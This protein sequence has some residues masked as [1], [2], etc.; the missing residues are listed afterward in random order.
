MK[1]LVADDSQ[2]IRERLVERLSQLPE[3]EIFEAVDTPT[4]LRQV[5]DALPDIAVL[6][7]RMPGGGGIKALKAIKQQNAEIT[8]IIMTNYPYA[9]Y[10]RKCFDAGADFF[11]DKSTE[12]ELIPDTIRLL[13]ESG[14][15][16]DVAYHV[17]SA[18][19][20]TAKEDLERTE[21]WQRDMSV[22]NLLGRQGRAGG[23]DPAYV[24]WEKTFDAM[25]DSVA[26]FDADRRI[27]RVNKVAAAHLG[28]PATELV[29]K[30]CYECFHGVNCPIRDC[31]HDKML[32]DN[33]AH[34]ADVYDEH[35]GRWFH[36]TVSPIFENSRLIGA[37]HVARDMTERKRVEAAVRKS[38]RDLRC[39]IDTILDGL[40]DWDVTTGIVRCNA[41]WYQML[42]Y[43]PEEFLMTISQFEQM[44]H[45]DDRERVIANVQ[46]LI[47]GSEELFGNEFRFK[48]K[49]GKYAW[50]WSR[51]GV[52]ERH[53]DGT[54]SRIMGVHSDITA[55]H[56]AAIM[57]QASE[58]R[59]HKLFESMQ[60]GFALHEIIYDESGHPGDC[61]FLEVNAAFEKLTGFAADALIG[62]KV[63]D[64]LPAMREFWIELYGQVSSTGKAV[65]FDRFFPEFRR[66]YS[67]SA[68]SPSVGLFAT[69]FT[70]VTDRQNA[71]EAIR[72]ARDSAEESS[73]AKT[74]FLANMSH[75]L[76]TPLNA[77]IGFTELL[78]D[79]P[80]TEEQ[81]DYI[82]TIGA[83]GEGLLAII[84]DLL[85]LSKIEMGKMEVKKELI[86]VRHVVGQ[87]VQC[88]SAQ[89]ALKDVELTSAIDAD[90]PD[91][92]V[93]DEVRLQ[94][95]LF[96]LLGN[97]LKFTENGFVQLSV[98]R[99][100]SPSGSRFVVFSIQDSGIGIHADMIERIFEPFQQGDNSSTREYSGAGLGLTI[101]KSLVEMMGGMI[102][103]RSHPGEGSCFTFHLPEA[104]DSI[105]EG[106]F[107]E[108]RR[109]WRDRTVAVW[110]DSPADL[111]TLESLLERCGIIPCYVE[112]ADAVREWLSGDGS[113]DAVLCNLDMP[114][115][116][117][118]DL[119][120]LHQ[121]YP[122]V[123]WVGLSNWMESVDEA[124]CDEISVFIDRP[125]RSDQLYRA[126]M[127]LC[128]GLT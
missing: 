73:R 62:Q 11:F 25:P 41:Q 86:S 109:M 119:K 64:V 26:I 82:Q 15:V 72:R 71:Q 31:P 84:A 58:Q 118:D 107:D 104:L 50:V 60:S 80:L 1:V 83:S 24:M 30:K 29:G 42:G 124:L 12:F 122:K 88:L 38:E 110:N 115:L 91:Q 125:V 3:L 66:H 39:V 117:A 102:H 8:V 33:K 18:Q 89:A 100:V 63:Q 40:W 81:R 121:L 101:S 53:A 75:E 116:V 49:D 120:A 27:I 13:M 70:D 112:S 21:Q 74:Q 19:L 61:R 47:N 14:S 69:I 106:S 5:L 79:S 128:R 85:D 78:I 103:V 65:Q 6:D 34:S 37:I 17:A 123:P 99:R 67:I 35:S 94:R 93:S 45:P 9:Q 59:Y 4:A 87:A 90:V 36:V 52:L 51:G 111:R 2:P 92:I 126:L 105:S 95:V 20:V 57:I 43:E 46:R 98:S 32:H 76:R 113:T 77:I 44:L 54:P 10:R 68:Y 23:D 108:V 97:A 48:R 22:L 127:Q 114:D 16:S 28:L 7:I 56:Q 55:K 96:N